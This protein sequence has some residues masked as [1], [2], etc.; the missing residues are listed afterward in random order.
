MYIP[1]RIKIS[2]ERFELCNEPV[3]VIYHDNS[4]GCRCPF[5]G[6]GEYGQKAEHNTTSKCYSCLQFH[7]RYEEIKE[8]SKDRYEKYKIVREAQVIMEKEEY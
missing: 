2:K 7:D 8:M 5:G 3:N 4:K 1:T 6:H